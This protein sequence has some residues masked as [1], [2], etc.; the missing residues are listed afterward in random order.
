LY[1]CHNIIIIIFKWNFQLY[2]SLSEFECEASKEW[3][4][5]KVDL[6]ITLE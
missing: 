6:N 3:T 4:K 5:W 1:Y 2:I